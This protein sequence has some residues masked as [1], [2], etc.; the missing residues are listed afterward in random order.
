MDQLVRQA[1]ASRDV[2]QAVPMYERAER[3]MLD[4]VNG[5]PLLYLAQPYI[6]QPYVRG[7]GYS[8][9]LDYRWEGVKILEH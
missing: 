7:A 3:M 2:R 6:V 4:D 1:D 9:I 8:G 5:A